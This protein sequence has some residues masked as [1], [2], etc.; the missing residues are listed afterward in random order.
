MIICVKF[1][2]NDYNLIPAIAT[3]SKLKAL[4]DAGN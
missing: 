3:G 4:D 1:D 2:R